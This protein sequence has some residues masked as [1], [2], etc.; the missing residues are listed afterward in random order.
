M[1][2]ICRCTGK[3]RSISGKASNWTVRRWLM[4]GGASRPLPP[5]VYALNKYVLGAEKLHGDDVPVPMLE[6]GNG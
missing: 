4:V 2:I 1:R 6:P 3:R 5:L